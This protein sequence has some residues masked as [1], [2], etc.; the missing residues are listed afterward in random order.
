MYCSNRDLTDKPNRNRI[1]C[2]LGRHQYF[3][4]S[5]L[6]LRTCRQKT[7]TRPCESCRCETQ[8]NKYFFPMTLTE[9]LMSPLDSLPDS[10]LLRFQLGLPVRS[11]TV[12]SIKL[13]W[14]NETNQ[15]FIFI[16]VE[17]NQAGAYKLVHL[18]QTLLEKICFKNL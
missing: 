10:D 4:E 18:K 14:F 15:T 8:F 11:F 17:R 12:V 5:C 6:K 16:T 1:D 2:I 9:I 3:C 7:G 13:F